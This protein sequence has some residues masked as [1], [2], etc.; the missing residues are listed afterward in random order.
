MDT[1]ETLQQ[2]MVYFS[3]PQRTFDTAVQFRWAGGKVTCPRCDGSKHSFIK[4]RRIW[5]C[6]DCKKQ[7]TV[8]VGTVMEDSPLGL[9]KWM[10]AIWMLTNC[11][12][13][14]SSYELAKALGI[15]QN[16][17]WFM[18]HRIREAMRNGDQTH[19]FGF[20]GPVESDE[21]YVGPNP[22]KMHASRRAKYHAQRGQ[23]MRGDVY[24]GKTAVHGLL[25]R[26]LR[27]VRAQVLKDVK[28]ETLQN[29][30]LKN[31][32]PFAKVYTDDAVAYDRLSKSFV[33]KVVDHSK[34][35]VNGQVH[36]QGI[37]NFWSL[38]K[39]TLRGTYVSVEPFH[40]D[41]YLDEQ[42]FR[43][44]NRATKDNPLNDTDRFAL[45]M[46]QVAGKRLTY[47]QLTGKDADTLHHPTAG[48]GQEEP[49]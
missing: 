7:F 2:A 3:D 37:E 10:I 34:E 19:K 42:V 27:Q 6:Y 46:S 17:A 47:A 15:R 13:G 4:T 36:T 12:N 16:S 32:T 40:L 25:D 38:L 41:S 5:F 8:K 33:H 28:R 14:M 11:K 30:I 9:D 43:Y 35:Y 21:T 39:R 49:F 24:V 1:P 31:V 44:N 48:T 18:L 23:G 29:I 45:A 26:E 22:R 20:G